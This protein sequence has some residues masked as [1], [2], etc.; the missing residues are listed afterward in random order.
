MP[1]GAGPDP[2]NPNR[3]A[4]V[5]RALEDERDALS[6]TARLGAAAWPPAPPAATVAPV[7]LPPLTLRCL[8]Y[9]LLHDHVAAAFPLSSS[10]N[11]HAGASP[12]PPTP[13]EALAA[14][15]FDEPGAE[16]SAKPS[17]PS[18]SHAGPPDPSQLGQ[19]VNAAT[20]SGREQGREPLYPCFGEGDNESGPPGQRRH[21]VRRESTPLACRP[22]LGSAAQTRRP[23]AQPSLCPAWGLCSPRPPAAGAAAGSVPAASGGQARG[24]RRAHALVRVRACGA[25]PG[26]PAHASHGG[27]GRAQ[28]QPGQPPQGRVQEAA[29]EGGG[30]PQQVKGPN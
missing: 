26:A 12:S 13:S 11:P 25:G 4:H 22:P 1:S 9:A 15:L 14:G 28:P 7:A 29:G 21:I 19:Q 16:A 8:L 3:P 20:T 6:L 27:A 5:R 18:P 2:Q 30:G 10:P 17:A 24:G 23:T